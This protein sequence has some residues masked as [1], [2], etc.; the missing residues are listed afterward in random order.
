MKKLTKIK[1]I[2]RVALQWVALGSA[3]LG[4]AAHAA[5]AAKAAPASPTASAQD[6]VLTGDA[7]CT[8]CHDDADAPGLLA[9][10]K[11]RHGVK[12]D[13]RNPTC[14]S[15]HGDSNEHLGYKGKDKPPKPDR[16]F[17][18]KSKTTPE[19]K[20][21]ACLSCH[22]KDAKRSHWEGS[23]HQTRDVACASCHQVHTSHDKVRDKLTQPEVCFTC[24][25]EQRAQVNK[26][27]HHPIVEGKM[28]CS[29]CHNPHG[30]VGPKLMKRDSVVETCYTCHMEKRGPFVHNHEPVS[31]D[32][33]NCHNPHGTVTE[34]LLKARPPFL[35][36]QCHTPHGG[37]IPQ[38]L[39][40]QATP[41]A[42]TMTGKSTTN[43]TQGRS[44]LNCHTQVHGSNNP[45]TT[46][47]TPQF[48][49]R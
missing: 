12:A 47:P 24:H 36:H 40:K 25:K 22:Q 21:E 38:L 27:S 15:C 2:V 1:R 23:I 34:S 8:S 37:F 44:C 26:P 16:T 30:S 33:S 3:L 9:I 35:C 20:N 41:N 45:A 39:G 28:T 7:K 14:T 42:A 10:G 48:N 11:T 29:D 43:L 31:E 5:D 18:K 6:L 17:D 13:A 19:A 32:C 49:F 46:N 4:G